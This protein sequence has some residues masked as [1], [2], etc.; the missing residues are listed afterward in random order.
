VE[1]DMKIIMAV[2][3]IIFSAGLAWGISRKSMDINDRS[4]D[5]M[6]NEIGKVRSGLA[7]H[8]RESQDRR[9]E[10]EKRLNE[11]AVVAARSEDR[12]HEM[13]EQLEK[14]NIKL[15]RLIETRFNNGK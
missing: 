5:D 1:I 7:I 12:Y 2:A 15:D 13:K 10:T 8:E 6:W 14:I 4:H 9:L 11:I 3:T